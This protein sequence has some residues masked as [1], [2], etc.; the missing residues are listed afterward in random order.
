MKIVLKDNSQPY[1]LHTARRVPIPSMK[2][3]E[4]ELARMKKAGIIE[5]IAEPTEWCSP[6]VPVP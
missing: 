6:M 2:K 5:E 3:V 1:S 4:E